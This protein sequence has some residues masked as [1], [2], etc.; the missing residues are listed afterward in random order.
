MLNQRLKAAHDVRDSY[1]AL[2]VG[3]AE[4]AAK[5]TAC[6]ATM[7]SARPRAGLKIG[8]GTGALARVMRAG[9]LL[10]EAEQLIAEA[11]PELGQLIEEAGL[12]RFFHYAA[13][14]DGYGQEN[15]SPPFTQARGEL[16]SIKA[17]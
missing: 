13:A 9:A 3:A 16:L 15:T 4:L 12:S 11:H 17:A 7:T 2:K 14:D 5:A 6:A 10:A 8:T 1:M